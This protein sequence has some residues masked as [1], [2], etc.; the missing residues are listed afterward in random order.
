MG[1]PFGSIG[2]AV[3]MEVRFIDRHEDEHHGSLNYAV[4]DCGDAQ[5][6]QFPVSL[7]YPNPP[8]RAGFVRFGSQLMQELVAPLDAILVAAHIHS[9]S[10]PVHSCGTAVAS[11]G[12]HGCFDHI[13]PAQL[14]IQT[15]EPVFG[16]C[17][18]FPIE[19][20]LQLPNFWRCCYPNEELSLRPAITGSFTAFGRVGPSAAPWLPRGFVLLWINATT[21]DSDFSLRPCR[22]DGCAILNG[23]LRLCSLTPGDLP[24]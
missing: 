20:Q 14:S 1:V 17:L 4:C 10:L 23:E 24:T 22:L 2:V 5:W 16:F 7:G 21:D 6:P 11:D 18:C 12:I 3:R 9:G 15:P 8:H 19:R 13:F